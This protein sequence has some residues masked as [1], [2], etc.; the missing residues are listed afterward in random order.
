MTS[1]YSEITRIMKV[2][3]MLID[4][5]KFPSL[6]GTVST[7]PSITLKHLYLPGNL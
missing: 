7:Q 5:T 2:I 3:D 1:A 6:G 4:N